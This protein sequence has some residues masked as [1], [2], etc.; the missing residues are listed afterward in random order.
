MGIMAALGILSFISSW[1]AFLWP[2]IVGQSP[3]TRTVQV[4][5][6][7]SYLTAQTID[8]TRLFAGAVIGAIPLIIIFLAATLHRARCAHVRHQGLIGRRG[9]RN[10]RMPWHRFE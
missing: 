6:L 7:S 1:N 9:I 5:V 8:L 4:V 10:H 2:V 3:G